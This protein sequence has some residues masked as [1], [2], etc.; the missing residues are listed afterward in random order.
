MLLIEQTGRMVP[1]RVK[2]ATSPA[3]ALGTMHITTGIVIHP[4]AKW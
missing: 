4:K 2:P 1:P 3:L